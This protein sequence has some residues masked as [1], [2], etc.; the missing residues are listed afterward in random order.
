LLEP[1]AHELERLAEPLFE[2][3]LQLFVDG[4][5]HLL[6]LG[7]VVGLQLRQLRFHG[8]PQFV[9]LLFLRL[10]EAREI[11]GKGIE[12]LLLQHR[13]VRDLFLQRVAEGGKR[14]SDLLAQL[15]I[16][17]L[18]GLTQGVEPGREILE[19]QLLRVGNPV[20][21]LHQRFRGALERLLQLVATRAGEFRRLLPV[22][23]ER[24]DH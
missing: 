14:F 24:I 4:A 1:F 20:D 22:L 2:R 18:A 15:R 11:R 17:R 8:E 3:A 7:R 19:S 21:A 13:H 16:A 5:A 6:E 12:L 10:G 9:G 23:Y